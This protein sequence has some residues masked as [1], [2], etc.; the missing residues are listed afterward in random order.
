[1][2]Y[3]IATILIIVAS[4]ASA[5]SVRN[6][7]RHEVFCQEGYKFLMTWVESGTSRPPTV[8][9]IFTAGTASDRPSHPMKCDKND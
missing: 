2:K 1:M 4:T 9:Q 6:H 8:V 5:S 7:I 3:L